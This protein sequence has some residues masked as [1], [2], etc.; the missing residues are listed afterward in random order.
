MSALSSMVCKQLVSKFHVVVTECRSSLRRRL[1][2]VVH[3]YCGS[4][5]ALSLCDDRG[6]K[7]D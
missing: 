3:G 5:G 6:S 7:A 2:L 4:I 1:M